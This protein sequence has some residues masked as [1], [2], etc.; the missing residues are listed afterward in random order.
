MEF[1]SSIVQPFTE[2]LKTIGLPRE[3]LS[4]ALAA[5]RALKIDPNSQLDGDMSDLLASL[6]ATE[7]DLERAA[8]PVNNSKSR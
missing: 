4:C 7:Q 2:H 6:G 1:F 5:K 8:M 3:A